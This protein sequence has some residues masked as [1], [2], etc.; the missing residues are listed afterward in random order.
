MIHED[1]G[2]LQQAREQA[3]WLLD[4]FPPALEVAEAPVLQRRK[5]GVVGGE[6]RVERHGE[7]VD[8]GG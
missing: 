8:D 5:G 7:D 3:A 4:A 6:E 1:P 2:V